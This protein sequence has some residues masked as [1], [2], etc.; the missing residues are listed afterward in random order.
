MHYIQ[1]LMSFIEGN[2]VLSISFSLLL[3]IMAGMVTHLI[4]KFFIVKVIRKVFFSSHKKGVPLDKD[5]RLSQKLSNFVPVIVVY[6]FLQF[7]PGLP[8]NLKVAIQTICGIL[9]FV[10]LSI[11]FNEVLE[12]V[13]NSYSRKSKR[14]NHSI[15][16]YIQ[17]GKILVHIIA[18]I[19]ILA[20]MS[21]KSPAIIISSLGAVAAVLMLIFQHTLLSLVANIQL[22]SN[23]VLQ[24]GDWIE[25]PD[26]NISGEVIDIALHTI[27]IRNW[28]NTI[29]RIPTKNFL[30]ETYTNWQAMFSSGARRIMRSFYLDQKSITFVNQ[31]ML[32]AMSQIRLAGESITELLDGRDINAVGDRWFMENGITNLMVFRKYLTAWLAQ[33]DDIQKEMYIVVRPLK[34]SPDGLPVEIYCFTS[35]IFWAD[36]E[37][38][39]AAIFEYIYAMARHFELQIYQHPAGSDFARLAQPRPDSRDAQQSGGQ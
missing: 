5:V 10:Y 29:S 1:S 3:L 38:T 26:R 27:T 14:K 24:L 4:C 39:Q 30:T 35:S 16:G 31:D 12:I 13:N 28:D 18:A 23:D 36:Y 21:N 20:I 6:N 11:F 8:E 22:S 34:P 33:R 17:I 9:F 25:M 19:M 32:Q 7:M 15:K 37:N 2:R